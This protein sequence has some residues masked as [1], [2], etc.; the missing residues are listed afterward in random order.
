M[1]FLNP[2][3]LIGLIAAGIPVLLHLLNLRKVRVVEFSTLSF[4]K[5]LQPTTLRRLRLRQLLLLL[6]RTLLIVF[7][8]LAFSRPTLEGSAGSPI[9]GRVRTTAVIAIDDSPSMERHNRGGTYWNQATSAAR[10]VL[11]LFEDGD[12]IILL[13]FSAAPASPDAMQPPG[14]R[15]I[16][17][18][19]AA[20]DELKPGTV[21]S[22]MTRVLRSSDA[23][24]ATS[25]NPQ[26]EL[27]VI[28]DFQEGLF[29]AQGSQ[30]ESVQGP[31]AANRVHAYAIPIGDG[32]TRNLGITDAQVTNSILEQGK[33]FTLS[34]TLTNASSDDYRNALVSVF[35]GEQR[36]TAKAVDVRAGASKAFDMSVVAS[37]S[38]FING[39]VMLEDDD[40]PF[41][42]LRHFCISLR[43][44]LRV[45]LIGPEQSLRYLRAAVGTRS[46]T[47]PTVRIEE[48]T[49]DRLSGSLIRGA[50]VVILSNVSSLSTSQIADLKA[51]LDSGGGVLVFPGPMMDPRSYRAFQ[52]ELGLPEFRALAV[53]RPATSSG[54]GSP[55]TFD[56]VD[57]RHPIFQQMFQP[58]MEL[59]SR[60]EASRL[61]SPD[62]WTHVQFAVSTRAQVVVAL[63][64]GSPFLTDCAIGK[65]RVLLF[66]VEAEPTW[67]DFPFKG[68]FV[69]LLLRSVSYVAQ[70]QAIMPEVL[71]GDPPPSFGRITVPG[72]LSIHTPTGNV[73]VVPT[74]ES[75]ART[76]LLSSA[77]DIGVYDVQA[78]SATVTR[79]VVNGAPQESL[80]KREQPDTLQAAATGSGLS[81]AD[82]TWID[83]S[84]AISRIVTQARLGSELWPIAVLAA[85]VM[86]FLELLLGRAGTKPP[87]SSSPSREA[88]DLHD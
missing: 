39:T 59:G 79:F 34:I 58:R 12:E 42:N 86:A 82:L 55:T 69:P 8:V 49:L 62:I 23:V 72:P 6:V 73:I 64:D 45:V 66:A 29:A 63:S 32:Q 17:Q 18:A 75:E 87:P 27:Y 74:L 14:V 11:E 38:G 28:S 65:G 22:P 13:P 41:D 70:E 76:P 1:T 19:Q 68:I 36:V 26:K 56:V 77:D 35:L 9:G 71:A 88:S 54:Q 15:A 31:E 10:Q 40:F 53:S 78:G 44:E 67:S 61:E 52:S 20:L 83:E 51:F 47:G 48:A 84:G 5:E 57:W 30:E 4:L 80:L 60:A 46:S 50:D 43:T 2:L 25:E 3:A 81:V 21:F 16:A 7:L 37:G 33:P 24:L 85:L